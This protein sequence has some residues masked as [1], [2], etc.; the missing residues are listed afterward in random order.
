MKLNYYYNLN[1]Q[2]ARTSRFF[3]FIVMDSSTKVLAIL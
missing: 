1:V 2:Q 3:S